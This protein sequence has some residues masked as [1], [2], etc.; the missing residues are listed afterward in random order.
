MNVRLLLETLS[1]KTVIP[2]AAVQRGSI[3]PFVY[4]V[5]GGGTASIKKVKLGTADGPDVSVEQ[6]LAIG[7]LV[8]TSGADR[9]REGALV[10]LP[11][12]TSGS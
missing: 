9:L 10:L 7:D 3:G 6:G 8:V 1:A 12:S 5:S 2:A 11:K 4:T